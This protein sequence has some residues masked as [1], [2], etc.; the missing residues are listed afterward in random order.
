MSNEMVLLGLKPDE[1]CHDPKYSGTAESGYWLLDFLI[2][3]NDSNNF[4]TSKLKFRD[5]IPLLSVLNTNSYTGKTDSNAHNFF[6]SM[7][8]LHTF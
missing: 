6:K 5:D 1:I 4:R 7:L 3:H 8:T 2:I